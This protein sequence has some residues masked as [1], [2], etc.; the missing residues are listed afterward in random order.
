MIRSENSR[1]K[2]QT[3][4]EIQYPVHLRS[5]DFL[6]QI[7]QKAGLLAIDLSHSIVAT[8]AETN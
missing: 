7:I 5:Y 6:I 3:A 2:I 4:S 8:I 1:F